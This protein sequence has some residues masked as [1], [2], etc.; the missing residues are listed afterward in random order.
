MKPVFS[1]ILL[2]FACTLFSCTKSD[3]EPPKPDTPEMAVARQAIEGTS[4]QLRTG[5]WSI[6][7]CTNNLVELTYKFEDYKLAF[8]SNGTLTAVKDN[9]GA[10]GKWVVSYVDDDVRISFTFA[11]TAGMD[12]IAGDWLL[13]KSDAKKMEMKRYQVAGDLLTLEK[14]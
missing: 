4:Q 13:V 8:A 12:A 3:I 11:N 6:S 1:S 14:N 5:N 10:M 7:N 2:L 9:I